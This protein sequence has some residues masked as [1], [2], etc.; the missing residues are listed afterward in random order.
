MDAVKI[1]ENKKAGRVSLLEKLKSSDQTQCYLLLGLPIIGFLVFTIYPLLWSALKAFYFYDMVPNHT[2][3]VGLENFVTLFTKG[4]DYWRGWIVTLQFLLIKLPIE[5]PL[6][7]IL[8]VLLSKGLRGS[9]LFRNLYYMPCV[10]SVAIVGIIFSNIFDVFGLANAWLSK[11]GIIDAPID[12]F[13][14]KW[15]ALFVLILGGIWSNM[16]TNV[17]YFTAALS[18]VPKELYEAAD[19][20]G[21]GV[22]TKFFKI[23]VPMIAKV[24]QTILL[25]AINGTLRV[26]EYIIVMTNGAPA[27]KTLTA[28]AYVIKTFL[29]GFAS[30]SSINI[31][32]G[33]AISII[34]SIIC[35]AIGIL[36]MRATRK[37]TEL[38]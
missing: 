22:C 13:G 29:P 21:A 2:R 4:S 37:V 11:L 34:S 12:W 33:C 31:G 6:A 3:F 10:I 25:L 14:G 27:G 35:A 26:G 24:F 19:M 15:T 23:T 18:N 8:A 9:N 17:V 36:Y 16:G 38:Y 7:L 32:Y 20:E 30:G 28:E 1:K 5:I